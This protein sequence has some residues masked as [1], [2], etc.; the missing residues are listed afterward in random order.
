MMIKG[1]KFIT[2]RDAVSLIE[3][4]EAVMID[5]REGIFKNGRSFEVKNLISIPYSDLKENISNIPE[6]KFVILADYVGLKSKSALEYLISIGYNDAASL[7]GGIA[8]WELDGLPMTKNVDEELTGG[9]AC[10]LRPRKI[11]KEVKK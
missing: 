11:K 5:L 8:E 7:I 4:D 1:M 3:A 10:Q 6:D 2:G 9:C